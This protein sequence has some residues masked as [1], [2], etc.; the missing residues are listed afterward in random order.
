MLIAKLE[1]E[2]VKRIK[3]VSIAPS[4]ELCILGGRN[5]QGK[6]SILDAIEMALAGKS[7]IPAEPIRRGS[8]SA[9]VVVTLDDGLVVERTFK[10]DN[11]YLVVKRG[12]GTKAGTPQALL[13]SLCSK[14]AFDPL[15]FMRAKPAE[16]ANQLRGLVGLDFRSQDAARK[17]AYDHRTDVN[18]QIKQAEAAAQAIPESPEV[19]EVSVADLMAELRRRQ[20][21]NAES[22]KAQAS[23][24]TNEKKL[25]EFVAKAEAL[26]KQIADLEAELGKVQDIVRKGRVWLDGE[27]QRV[28]SLPRHDLAEIE[29]QIANSESVNSK[30]RQNRKRQELLSEAATIKATAD[31]LTR[32]IEAIDA[33]KAQAMAGAKWPV[34]GLGFSDTGVTFQGLPLEQASSAEQ[35]R[36]SVAIGLAFNPKLKVLL[37]RDG[38]LLDENSLTIVAKMAADANGQVWI[39]RVS[40]GKE[41]QVIIE[42]G[43]IVGGAHP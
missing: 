23:I 25:G 1:V 18:R 16:Q 13:D 3:A 36:V 8:E 2:N 31:E 22:D 19:C 33:A 41:C 29:T 32:Q 39:E 35:L 42:D 38:S 10:A 43:A 12:D 11:S 14:I 17:A 24:V 7:A 20:A 26:Q 21:I 15:A 28:S 5:A 40:N 6:S 27:K 4:G 34:P 37:I 30:V 9:R